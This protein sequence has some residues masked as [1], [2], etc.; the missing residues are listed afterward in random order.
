MFRIG[1]WRGRLRRRWEYLRKRVRR[2]FTVGAKGERCAARYLRRRGYRILARNWRTGRYELDIVASV[3]G[4]LV[5]V[6]VKTRTE[7]AWVGGAASV[8]RRK[9]RALLSATRRLVRR[10]HP[11]PQSLQF[12]IVEVWFCKDGRHHVSHM[13]NIDLF[14]KGFIIHCNLW[15][16]IRD[17]RSS[18]D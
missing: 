10:I 16:Q 12:D 4:V 11:P 9:R 14:P 7:G 17:T 18:G 8:D 6:E 2:W 5:I 13:P 3:R 15:P 1:R